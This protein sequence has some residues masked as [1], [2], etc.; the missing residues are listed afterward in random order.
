[1][2]VLRISEETTFL[3]K[4]VMWSFIFK[5]KMI[6]ITCSNTAQVSFQNTRDTAHESKKYIFLAVRLKNSEQLVFLNCNKND[7]DWKMFYLYDKEGEREYSMEKLLALTVI[8][9][10]LAP[11][12]IIT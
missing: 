8:L 6:I 2:D 5:E 11:L 4:L 3:K 7:A 12:A 10:P 9:L 1:M